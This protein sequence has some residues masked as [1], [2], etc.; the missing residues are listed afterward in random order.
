MS[1]LNVTS[2]S[3]SIETF[4]SIITQFISQNSTIP[5]KKSQVFFTA[6]D[7]AIKVKIYQDECEPTCDNMPLSDFNLV[8]IPLAPMG[9]P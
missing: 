6:P 4:G 9:N 8:S 3:L 5:T 2:L 7:S 1:L